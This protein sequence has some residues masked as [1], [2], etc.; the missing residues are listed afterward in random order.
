[1]NP[2]EKAIRSIIE[3]LF[4]GLQNNDIKLLERGYGHTRNLLVFPE[5]PKMKV[6]G[7]KTMRKAIADFLRTH[8]NI[9]SRLN[10]DCRFIADGRLGVY[11]GT[12]RFGAV[13]RKTGKRIRFTARN[14]F[15]FRKIG[16]HWKV[17]HEHDSFPVPMP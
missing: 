12:Y 2:G 7:W 15:I 13:N 10:K 17:V 11:Y 6:V 1:M 5:G 14:T 8:T 16:R 9:Q 3:T 4:E